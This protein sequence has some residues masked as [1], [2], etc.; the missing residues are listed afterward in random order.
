MPSFA[1]MVEFP[2]FKHLEFLDEGLKILYEPFI[3]VHEN[4]KELML[5][6]HEISKE[7]S[8]LP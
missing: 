7:D 8:A 3:H 2:K 4:Q 1:K 5:F 6:L